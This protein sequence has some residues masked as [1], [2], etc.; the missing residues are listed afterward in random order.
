M[1]S[2]PRRAGPKLAI[3]APVLGPEEEAAALEVLRS[4]E[5]VSG[6]RVAEFEHAFAEAHGAAHG[7]ATSSGATALTATLLAHGIGP[8]DEVIVPSFSFF[9]TAACVLGAGA[10]P[11]FADIDAATYCLSAAAAEAA[12]TPRTRA[13]MP[14]HLF[15]LA[16]DMAA[17]EA[18][19]LR[20]GLLLFEDAAQAHGASY[21]GRKVGSFGTAAFSFHASK[22][23]T[24]L[25][26]GMVL[27]SDAAL[28]RRL[29]QLR[30][31]GREPGGLHELAGS[32]FRM[33]ELAAA[34]GL[35]QLRRLPGLNAKRRD[36]ARALGARLRGLTPPY[37]PPAREH[38]FQQYTL[39][40]PPGV[41]RDALVAGLEELGIEARVYYGTPIHA[42]P[43]LA[44]RPQAAGALHETERAAR[45]VLSVPVHP[46]LRDEDLELIASSVST[47]AERLASPTL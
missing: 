41:T 13:V 23:M 14:V 18:L 6:R 27:T 11:V 3:A 16:A 7:V 39:R 8:G 37:E 38:V 32:N 10:T 25:E 5:L 19:A 46:G 45:E 12:V 42:Q 40:A 1:G 15:G 33:T 31:H 20:H 36:N 35:V 2:E 43:A 22:N 9:A 44:G 26:G 29:R 28:A 34:I 17:F 47:L 21:H 24:T 4:G 30:N